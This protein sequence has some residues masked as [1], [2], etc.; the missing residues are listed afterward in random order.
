MA[1]E[2]Y[3]RKPLAY[4]AACL[5]LVLC[6]GILTSLLRDYPMHIAK[7]SGSTL[8]YG[9]LGGLVAIGFV[10]VSMYGAY[11]VLRP[12]TVEGPLQRMNGH[13][14]IRRDNDLVINIAGKMYRFPVD[15]GIDQ[16]LSA[17]PSSQPVQVL[18]EVGAFGYALSLKVR[19]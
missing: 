3:S 15:S 1:I 11:R 14:V 12:S 2:V 18:M 17:S 9:I 4:A 10:A 8:A 7:A 19:P 16:K 5:C 13:L 6:G